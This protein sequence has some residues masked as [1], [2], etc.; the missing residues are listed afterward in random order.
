M[1]IISHFLHPA[2]NQATTTTVC[3]NEA[4][5]LTCETGVI[6]VISAYYGQDG[7][8]DDCRTGGFI[9]STCAA[10]G[11]LLEV[12][13][14]CQGKA[15]C[16]FTADLDVFG[17]PC[18]AAKY[19]RVE[20]H[21]TP[22]ALGSEVPQTPVRRNTPQASTMNLQC[23]EGTFLDVQR[24]RF[25]RPDREES[26]FSPSAEAIITMACQ[27]QTQCEVDATVD[28]LGETCEPSNN[29]LEVCIG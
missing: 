24:V 2:V 22:E 9:L 16:T 6:D 21:C 1:S 4:I 15:T 11:T 19:A 5:T 13:N 12:Q 27:G 25:G 3:E 8:F 7:Q 17:V 23:P 14:R 28:N 18:T 26:C 20:H 29:M 10:E